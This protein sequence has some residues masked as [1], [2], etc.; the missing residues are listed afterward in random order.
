M[1]PHAPAAE[2]ADASW[3][4]AIHPIGAC[5]IGMETPRSLVTRFL[6]GSNAGCMGQPFMGPA[7]GSQDGALPNE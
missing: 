2:T 1:M 4:R 3:L 6:S 7:S 5:T